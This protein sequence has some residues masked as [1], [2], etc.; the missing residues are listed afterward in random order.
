MINKEFK[1]DILVRYGYILSKRYT[2]K[3]KLRASLALE[4]D[5]RSISS[6]VKV[7][8]FNN[9]DKKNRNLYVGSIK[10]A[11][12]ILATYYDTP[13][14]FMGSYYP[15]DKKLQSRNSIIFIFLSSLIAISI[16]ILYTIF[17]AVD[18]LKGKNIFSLPALMIMISYFLFFILFNRIVRGTASRK[19]KI[20]NSSSLIYILNLIA[21][22]KFNKTISFAFL[23]SGCTNNA[24]LER[25]SELNS[26]ANII[27]LDS[28]GADY[29]LFSFEYKHNKELFKKA[30]LPKNVTLK[31]ATEYENGKYKVSRKKLNANNMKVEN[32]EK[33]YQE[34]SEEVKNV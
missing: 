31:V 33:L 12:I 14:S 26:D 13:S 22:G 2:E 7:D 20:R 21:E 15:L 3:Q 9:K 27:Y 32:F 1:K 18:V 28:I 11:K 29:D 4:K 34:L 16:A 30:Y 10:N 5:L 24:G 23:D 19:T 6:N 8:I 17:F 25:L